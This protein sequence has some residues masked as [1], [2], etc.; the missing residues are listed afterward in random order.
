V[1]RPRI[2]MDYGSNV[3]AQLPQIGREG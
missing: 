1:H 2:I 3:V